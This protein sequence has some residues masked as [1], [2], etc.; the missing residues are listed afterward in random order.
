MDTFA[1]MALGS[2]RPH[3]SI[4]N[5]PPVKDNENIMTITMWK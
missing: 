3:P 1:A 5:R 4:I 2:E